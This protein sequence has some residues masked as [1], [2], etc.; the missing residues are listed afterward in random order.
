M[1][2]CCV[3]AFLLSCVCW[4]TKWHFKQIQTSIDIQ[5]VVDNAQGQKIKI[6]LFD[7]DKASD[8]ESLGS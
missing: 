3:R 1:C 8:D 4:N 6:K 7:E 2:V 5:V